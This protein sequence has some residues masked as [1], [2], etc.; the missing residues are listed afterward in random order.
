MSQPARDIDRPVLAALRTRVE[1]PVRR[2]DGAEVPLGARGARTRAALLAAAYDVF[3]E[4]G[5]QNSSVA[6]IAERASVGTGTFYQY[7]RD[8]SDVLGELVN[9]GISFLVES[10][11]MRWRVSEGRAGLERMLSRFVAGYAEQAPFWAMWEEVTHTDEQLA[12]VRRD[13]SR[14]LE[15]MVATELRRGRQQ[16]RLTT[17]TD[18][19]ATARAL[20]A[21]VDRF[22]YMTYIFDPAD[23]PMPAARAV[24]VLT[25]L[26]MRA[27]E[28]D[29]T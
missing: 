21:M 18:V 1:A 27:I 11:E 15:E 24:R 26:W 17:P 28:L 19:A 4:N 8:R 9:V 25:D 2:E 16:R 22:C 3:R 20:T 23:P 7:F 5:F 14:M 13:L 6:L 12:A 10:G 29:F